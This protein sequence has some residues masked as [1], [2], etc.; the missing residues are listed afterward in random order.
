MTDSKNRFLHFQSYDPDCP[1]WSL[2]IRWKDLEWPYQAH[3]DGL[4]SSL[5]TPLHVEFRH[6]MNI[7]IVP[8]KLDQVNETVVPHRNLICW[9]DPWLPVQLPLELHRDSVCQWFPHVAL[10]SYVVTLFLF[11]FSFLTTLFTSY[12]SYQPP[13][14][15][16]QHDIISI[17]NNISYGVHLDPFFYW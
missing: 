4:L 11:L 9:N 5:R 16:D 8:V 15:C 3:F 13:T 2:L 14:L 10:M 1:F 6:P 17:I 12:M 7:V